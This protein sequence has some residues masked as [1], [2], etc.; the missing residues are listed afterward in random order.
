MARSFP[1]VG[2]FRH[3]YHRDEV[4]EFM[5]Q[6]TRAY[7]RLAQQRETDWDA[8][9]IR[10]A[11]FKLVRGGFDPRT[12]DRA[13]DRLEDAFARRARTT[14]MTRDPGRWR[15]RAADLEASL[16]GRLERPVGQRFARPRL[17]RAGYDKREVDALLDEVT[18]QLRH[19]SGLRGADVRGATFRRARGR[20]AY[21]E[22]VVDA[23]LDRVVEALVAAE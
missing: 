16:L 10:G 8:A 12:V 18:A 22:A 21:A 6:A 4:T 11:S 15:A 13:L 23:Y 1:T 2:I 7:E 14:G 5:L 19:D 9:R 17:G 20:R 3:G